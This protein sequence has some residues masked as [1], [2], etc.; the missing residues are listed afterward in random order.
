MLHSFLKVSRYPPRYILLFRLSLRA[1][2]SS[3]RHRAVQLVIRV[4][5]SGLAKQSLAAIRLICQS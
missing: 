4:R 5:G 3:Y 1:Q 2:N